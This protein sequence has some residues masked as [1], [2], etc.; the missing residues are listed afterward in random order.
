MNH[1]TQPSIY[2]WVQSAESL[3][4]AMAITKCSMRQAME[5]ASNFGHALSTTTM[6]HGGMTMTQMFCPDRRKHKKLQNKLFV[7]RTKLA[8]T[9]RIS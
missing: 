9:I 6:D 2:L 4:K 7:E 1:R 5:E 3:V 8:I